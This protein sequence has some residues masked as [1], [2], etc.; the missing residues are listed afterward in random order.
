VK[1]Q[2]AIFYNELVRLTHENKPGS[3]LSVRELRSRTGLKKSD[4]DEVATTLAK[5]EVVVL[6]HHDWPESL[7]S[8]ERAEL[9]QDIRGNS[10]VGLA[11]TRDWS[12]RK[13]L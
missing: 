4:F 2:A 13:K 9:V 10:Y 7:K 6:H 1:K 8:N 12:K 3:L 11:F 5:N